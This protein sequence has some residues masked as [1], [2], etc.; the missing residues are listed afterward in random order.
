MST[1][2]G[3]FD[4]DVDDVADMSLPDV[5][6]KPSTWEFFIEKNDYRE[7]TASDLHNYLSRLLLI[8]FNYIEYLCHC[9]ISALEA[10]IL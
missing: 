10:G 1:V 2:T 8:R 5:K 7:V 9:I 3:S 6:V 4:D